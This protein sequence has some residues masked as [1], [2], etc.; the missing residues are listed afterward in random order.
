MSLG[1]HSCST[2]T[3]FPKE[4]CASHIQW[5]MPSDILSYSNCFFP[6]RRGRRAPVCLCVC[7]CVRTTGSPSRVRVF[8][9]FFFIFFRFIQRPKQRRAQ[10][11][12]MPS[13]ARP[14]LDL[15]RRQIFNGIRTLMRRE[16]SRFRDEVRQKGAGKG[17][18]WRRGG[19]LCTQYW[20]LQTEWE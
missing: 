9:L 14:A 11:G 15:R 4:A 8:Q 1:P 7:A 18:R 5:W 16:R 19:R 20:K 10:T 6:R 12:A 13:D 3:Y 17:Q 2:A